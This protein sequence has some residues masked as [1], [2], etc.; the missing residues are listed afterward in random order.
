MSIDYAPP[1]P[2]VYTGPVFDL[3]AGA[4]PSDIP[5]GRLVPIDGIVTNQGIV[6]IYQVIQEDGSPVAR[7]IG[8]PRPSEGDSSFLGGLT[9]S[10]GAVFNEVPILQMA[11]L[12]SLSGLANASLLGGAGTAASDLVAI[13]ASMGAPSLIPPPVIVEPVLAPS[14]SL[15]GTLAQPPLAVENIA[16]QL[17]PEA[18][19]M[20]APSAAAT[21]A[22]DLAAIE[23]S[24][25]TPAALGSAEK[26]ALYGAEG[27]GP[28]LI[29]GEAPIIE[30]VATSMGPGKEV[31]GLQVA[32][33]IITNIPGAAQQYA[34]TVLTT[35]GLDPDVVNKIVG[36][37][38]GTTGGS[39]TTTQPGNNLA[40]V[41][42]GSLLGRQAP[43]APQAGVSRGQAV[44]IVSP[45][46]SLLAPKL[47][48]QRPVSLL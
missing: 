36:A 15:T 30:S 9:S 26:A 10:L 31:S 29:S 47:V 39:K 19:S 17:T 42:L 22:A 34:T 44:N 21:A 28:G 25:G 14:T 37:T 5:A 12:A 7:V 38:G 2:E 8:T 46:E 33:D 4:K 41:V 16:A 32:K 45:I 35:L 23:A 3:N 20:L 24:M 40:G 13:E 11:A 48:Q 27:Y 6:D 43:A 18:A 1:E